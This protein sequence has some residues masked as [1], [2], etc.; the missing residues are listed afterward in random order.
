MMRIDSMKIEQMKRKARRIRRSHGTLDK[1]LPTLLILAW[2]YGGVC[3]HCDGEGIIL[4]NPI[5]SATSEGFMVVMKFDYNTGPNGETNQVLLCRESLVGFQCLRKWISAGTFQ[6]GEFI[7][8]ANNPRFFEEVLSVSND[9][10]FNAIFPTE[11]F[12]EYQSQVGL[13]EE[14]S[15]PG[16]VNYLVS[17]YRSERRLYHML[18]GTGLASV[19]NIG[20][21]LGGGRYLVGTY[22]STN[23]VMETH[24]D[25]KNGLLSYE[26]R[27]PSGGIEKS[28][29]KLMPNALNAM[30]PFAK[31]RS[32]LLAS[33]GEDTWSTYLAAEFYHV[34]SSFPRLEELHKQIC[35][36][37][38]NKH[39]FRTWEVL[40]NGTIYA[41]SKSGELKPLSKPQPVLP[42]SATRTR[43]SWA[44]VLLLV[45]CFGSLAV[46]VS[47]HL[48]QKRSNRRSKKQQ[49][50]Q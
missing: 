13:K 14:S 17:N 11:N 28:E 15:A 7:Q 50:I 20:K 12:L 10:F 6:S 40:S 18:S 4:T 42:N 32:G 3:L 31:L 23:A 46:F 39:N 45:A 43:T 49:N 38:T 16:R 8:S 27:T 2:L 34:D 5:V 22:T 21:D 26:I 47:V 36:L 25:P 48:S 30:Q 1:P 29:Y 9:H 37:A 19:T 24:S 41:V 44:R 33:A 35:Q